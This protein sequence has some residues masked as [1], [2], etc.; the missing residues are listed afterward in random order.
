VRTVKLVVFS[1]KH[2]WSDTES[3]TGYVTDGGFPFQMK[4]IS[5]LFDGTCLVL[6]LAP[7]PKRPGLIPFEGEHLTIQPLT[8]LRGKRWRRKLMFPL[9]V[10]RNLPRLWSSCRDADGVHV[11][12]PGDVGTIGMILARIQGK[13]LFVRYCGNWMVSTTAAQKLWKRLMR[14]W[15][16]P[17]H[18]ML[19]TGG[20]HDPPDPRA[21]HVHWI[22]ATS[23][24]RAQMAALRGETRSYPGRAPKIIIVG[25]QEIEKGTGILID[26]LPELMKTYPEVSLDVVGD[27]G[28][29]ATFKNQSERLGLNERIEFWGKLPHP[30]VMER[31]RQAH[32]FCFPTFASE[33][34]PKVVL[35]ALASGLPVVTTRVSALPVVIGQGGGELMPE[36]TAQA[37]IEGIRNILKTPETY[38]TRSQEALEVAAQYSL[39]AW[40]DQIG[41]HLERAWGPLRT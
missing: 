11:A 37:C 29:L 31:L 12:I 34:F 14:R 39:E 5:Q 1:H 10:L 35:E 27:G 41:M 30:Q 16:K 15:N 4:G 3:P 36:A 7:N 20:S 33:G 22:F 9:W 2:I 13:P 38:A 32:L 24:D 6:P 40:R 18:V 17:H 19:A 25:R 28:A 8:P 23:L 26:C 21:P